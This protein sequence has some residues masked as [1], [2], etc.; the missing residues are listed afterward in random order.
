MPHPLIGIT[1]HATG[2]TDRASLDLLLDQIVTA[3][4]RAGGLPVLIPVGLSEATLRSLIGRMDGLLLSGGG[5]LDPASYGATMIPAMGGVDQ[6]RDATELCLVRH[7]LAEARPVLGICRGL[8]LLNVAC[9]GTL[10][11]DVSE[12]AG[13]M[14]HTWYPDLPFDL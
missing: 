10:Y 9:G 6:R 12:H 13:S 3:V 5:D 7:A 2:A 1:T 11:R 4:A 14:R 8:Q